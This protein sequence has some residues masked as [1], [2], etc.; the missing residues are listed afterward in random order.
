[1]KFAEAWQNTDN[2]G[3]YIFLGKMLAATLQIAALS[4]AMAAVIFKL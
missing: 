1:M 2:F 4:L 3:R